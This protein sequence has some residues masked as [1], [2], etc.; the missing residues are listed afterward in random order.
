LDD[1]LPGY[2]DRDRK[3]FN[4]ARFC[5]NDPKSYGFIYPKHRREGATSK[6]E[7][8]MYC[9]ISILH[10]A[11]GGIQSMT[12]SHAETVFQKHLVDPWKGNRMP[13]FFKPNT[14]GG[15]D[16]K[17]KLSF[18]PVASKGT[19]GNKK[20]TAK[21]L[22][23]SITYAAG[24]PKAYD[25]WK[26]HF[27]HQDECGKSEWEN[28]NNRWRIV[29]LCLAQSAG[30]SIH[31]LSIHTSTV[32]EMAKGGEN[33][34]TMCE[35]SNYDKRNKNGQTT[36]GLYVLFIPAYDGL[37]VY[38]D[39]FG[40]SVIETP[41]KEQTAFLKTLKNSKGE[42]ACPDP[43]IGAKEYIANTI[44]H[45][46]S[47]DDFEELSGFMRQHPTSYRGCFIGDVS[48]S[49]FNLVKLTDRL[50]ELRDMPTATVP[51]YFKW[52]G[53]PYRS[54]VKFVPDHENPKFDLSKQLSETESNRVTWDHG[55][56]SYIAHNVK[57]CAG[58]DPFKAN[59]TKAKKNSLGGGAVFYGHDINK[60]PFEKAMEE[61]VSNTFVCTYLNK[62]SDKDEYHEDMIM[63]CMYYGCPM[64]TET[65]VQD[66]KDAFIKLGFKGM[67]VHRYN[68]AKDQVEEIAGQAT[69][70]KTHQEIF[71]LYQQYVNK[72]IHKEKHVKL[73]QQIMDTL[74]VDDM[75]K[76]DLFAAGGYAMLGFEQFGMDLQKIESTEEV[77]EG[78][79]EYFQEYSY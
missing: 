37:D 75:T 68:I 33:F 21:G 65:N 55:L 50:E 13:F 1:G 59:D 42:I 66:L 54:R 63:M 5:F 24:N 34:R 18:R 57:M 58:A 73:V 17:T 79:G 9:I 78:E 12:D 30:A 61:W 67:L 72:H 8:I 38:I 48:D 15:D 64:Y 52:E 45:L 51:G 31:G 29:K 41:T 49:F 39:E 71:K 40:M 3:F 14:D 53:K 6:A 23:S 47:I 25:T 36:T 76:N 35:Q 19:V 77:M 70:T 56:Q 74:S 11:H 43:Y 7:C 22:L 2:R 32:G 26:L 62:P 44:E 69:S 4:F 60:D 46:K 28:V 27:Y 10:R 20:R 16:P